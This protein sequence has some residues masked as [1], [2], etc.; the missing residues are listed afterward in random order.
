[1]DHACTYE[2]PARSIK[3]FDRMPKDGAAGRTAFRRNRRN[4]SGERGSRVCPRKRIIT[5]CLSASAGSE[6]GK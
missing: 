3:F 5:A 2:F 1:M 4:E 6:A